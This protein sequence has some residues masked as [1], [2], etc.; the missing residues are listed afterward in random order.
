MSESA[1]PSALEAFPVVAEFSIQWGDLD[2]YGHVNHL[3]YLRWFEAVRAIY[4][5][6]VGV[7]V[8]PG[9]QGIGAVLASVSCKYHRQL[10]YPGAVM[11]GV[12]ATRLSIGAVGLEFRVVDRALGTPVAEGTCDAVLYDYQ[13]GQPAPIPDSIRTAVEQLEGRSFQA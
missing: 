13:Q 2:A 5:T 3:V 7:E 4:A 10:G 12:R 6:R 8:L 9:G 11:T 1:R